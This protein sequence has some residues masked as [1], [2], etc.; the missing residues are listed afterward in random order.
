MWNASGMR[1]AQ[2]SLY[3]FCHYKKMHKTLMDN[4]WIFFRD[5]FG[6]WQWER[7]G[8]AAAAASDVSFADPVACRRDAIH[9]GF[10]PMA[11]QAIFPPEFESGPG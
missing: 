2:E 6:R 10:L 3:R 8:G 4:R 7:H 1:V 5:V 9:H 11:D